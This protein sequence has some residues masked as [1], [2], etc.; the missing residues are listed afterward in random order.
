MGGLF[1]GLGESRYIRYWLPLR[2][3][4]PA[5]LAVTKGRL[6]LAAVL[7]VEQ[8]CSTGVWFGASGSGTVWSCTGALFVFLA[9]STLYPNNRLSRFAVATKTC[10][11]AKLYQRPLNSMRSLCVFK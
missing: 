7:V 6:E 1:H 10:R 4:P 3:Y 9:L 11:A 5:C 2:C 8:A